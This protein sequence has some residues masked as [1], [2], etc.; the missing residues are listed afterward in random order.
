MFKFILYFVITILV[1]W[2]MDT[3]N[4][5]GIFKKNCNPLKARLFYFFLALSMIYL[6][7]NF[8]YD[9]FTNIKIL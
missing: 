6:V 5:N 2:S 3:I 1:I 9:L 4:I 7:T 8:Y